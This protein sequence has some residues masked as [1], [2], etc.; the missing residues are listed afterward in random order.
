M[1]RPRLVAFTLSLITSAL[2]IDPAF[3]DRLFLSAEFVPYHE[4]K[5]LN[6]FEPNQNAIIA[7]DGHEEILFLT[8]NASASRAVKVLEVLPLPSKPTVTQGKMETRQISGDDF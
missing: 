3:S 7:F 5:E 1:K 2:C 6:F 4:K 8:T